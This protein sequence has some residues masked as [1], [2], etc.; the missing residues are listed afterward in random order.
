MKG[1]F[2]IYACVTGKIVA[3]ED[4]GMIAIIETKRGKAYVDVNLDFPL[5]LALGDNIEFD[6]IPYIVDDGMITYHL[7]VDTKIVVNGCMAEFKHQE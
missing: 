2:P 1:D 7:T 5:L 4:N 3:F 6:E